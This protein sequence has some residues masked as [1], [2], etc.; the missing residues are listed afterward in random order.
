MTTR[1]YAKI[2][3]GLR[4]LRKRDD[5]YH[6]IETIFHRIN[7]FDEI[8]F[9]TASTI[10]MTCNKHDLPTDDRNLCVRAAVLLQKMSGIHEGVHITLKKNI[11]VGAGLGGGSADAA[12]VLRTLP[13]RWGVP[14]NQQEM[15]N[16]ALELGSDVPYFLQPGSAY[17]T[18]KGELLDYFELDPDYWIVLVYPN[19]QISTSWA[20]QHVQVKG[21]KEKG[22]IPFISSTLKDIVVENISEPR[23]LMNFLPN[24]FEPLILRT[25]E[26]VA[27]V[28]Q[29]LYVAGAAFAQMSGSGSSV[30]GLFQKES[31]AKDA[32]QELAKPYH[33][34]VTPPHFKP[35]M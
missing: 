35:E 5:G 28:K 2:N 34:S 27:R 7:V 3:L 19:I 24:D 31:H 33:V 29:A 18:G 25:Y 30:Y 11:P 10:S 17:A 21:K 13:L 1:A 22:K 4:I 32:A 9:E 26:P 15:F 20:Y 23:M 16:L 14:V 8:S 12:T 6:D